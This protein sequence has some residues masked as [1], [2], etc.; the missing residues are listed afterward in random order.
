[1]E[2]SFSQIDE[3]AAI[4]EAE[5]SGAS[6]DVEHGSRLAEQ[7]AQ[8]CPDIAHTMRMV[9]DRLRAQRPPLSIAC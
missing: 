3:L 2:Y 4:L 6:V 9:A 1:M 7:L 5:I 8:L